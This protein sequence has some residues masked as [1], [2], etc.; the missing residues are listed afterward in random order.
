MTN[1][2]E[3]NQPD[4]DLR[5]R[6]REIDWRVQRLESSQMPAKSIDEAFQQVYDELDELQDKSD[7]MKVDISA[8]KVDISAMKI[9]IARLEGKIDIILH[10]ITG[11]GS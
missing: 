8:M 10:H 1:S 3:S 7:A 2:P 4:R 6:I 11:L 5:R 9:D